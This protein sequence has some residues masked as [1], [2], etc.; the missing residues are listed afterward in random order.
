[1]GIICWHVLL[2]F[3]VKNIFQIPSHYILQRW[4]KEENK[5]LKRVEYRSSF[6]DEHHIQE[7]YEASMFVN[8]QV[9]CLTLL[10]NLKIYIK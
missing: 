1:M 3:Q 6:E 8:V 4:T 7:P 5:E 10:K 9:N 2:I